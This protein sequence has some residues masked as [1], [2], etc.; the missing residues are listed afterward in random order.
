MPVCAP[1]VKQEPGI[2]LEGGCPYRRGRAA[3]AHH[4]CGGAIPPWGPAVVP[5]PGPARRQAG[6]WVH[7]EGPE[8]VPLPGSVSPLDSVKGEAVCASVQVAQQGQNGRAVDVPH[9]GGV[10][11]HNLHN[12][13]RAM[14]VY[15]PDKARDDEEVHGLWSTQPLPALKEACPGELLARGSSKNQEHA[16]GRQLSEEGEQCEASEEIPDVTG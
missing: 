5:G 8:E 11:H 13:V 15:G 6:P 14:P 1:A 12:Q 3:G 9:A 7:R 4:H 16:V 2:V 10:F